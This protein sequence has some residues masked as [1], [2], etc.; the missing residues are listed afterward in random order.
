[1][2]FHKVLYY[3]HSYHLL[4][5]TAQ[6]LTESNWIF[7]NDSLTDSW[8]KLI[9]STCQCS[10]MDKLKAVWGRD[11]HVIFSCG[12]GVSVP[13]LLTI[14]KKVTPS[15]NNLTSILAFLYCNFKLTYQLLSRVWEKLDSMMHH[16]SLIMS[17]SR[18]VNSWKFQT[19]FSTSWQAVIIL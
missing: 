19:R 16:N 10:P 14:N 15:L 3:L 7:W 9:D 2:R 4:S 17:P 11:V 8:D 18:K 12:G 13:S 5:M 6:H 1:M